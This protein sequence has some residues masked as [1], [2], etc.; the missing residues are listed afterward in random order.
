MATRKRK[1]ARSG[2]KRRAK[3]K[4]RPRAKKRTESR[5]P[6][7]RAARKPVGPKRAAAA[8]RV[9]PVAAPQLA[10]PRPFAASL[11]VLASTP[12]RVGTVRDYFARRG[13]ALVSLDGSLAV[14]ERIL[15]R[16][17]TSDFLADVSSL[18]AHGT[19]VAHVASGDVTLALPERARPGDT[20]FALRAAE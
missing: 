12:V 15:V 14:G 10:P 1:A 16:G 6:K 11:A 4:P 8:S 9:S 20:L 13:V 18:R 17:P 5:G 2:A 3:P 19:P 7:K